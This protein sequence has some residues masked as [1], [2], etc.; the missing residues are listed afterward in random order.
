MPKI[1]E[2]PDITHVLNVSLSGSRYT[3][4]KVSRLPILSIRITIAR[5]NAASLVRYQSNNPIPAAINAVM[6]R[7]VN[8]PVPYLMES[9]TT[10]R[11]ASVCP[12]VSQ[13]ESVAPF[14][15]C[16]KKA[17]KPSTVHI[18]QEARCGFVFS[19][20]ISLI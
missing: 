7:L 12:P 8:P 1:P 13:R 14:A 19:R 3:F 4:S 16:E 2:V 20:N 18:N 10:M 6:S 17:I 5:A 15:H 11:T 9:N